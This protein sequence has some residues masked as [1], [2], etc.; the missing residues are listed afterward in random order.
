MKDKVSKVYANKINKEFKNNENV[1]YGW[2]KSE[3]NK[4]KLKGNINQKLNQI[5]NSNEYIYKA[6]VIITLNDQ[7]INKRIIGR[8][9][10]YLITIDSELIPINDI[11]DIEYK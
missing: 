3:I 9:K 7:K 6:D 8:N 5:F 10:K 1:S 11:I 2:K 4:E